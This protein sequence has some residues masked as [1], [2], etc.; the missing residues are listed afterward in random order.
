[1]DNF[2][3][4]IHLEFAMHF[5]RSFNTPEQALVIF[6]SHTTTTLVVDNEVCSVATPSACVGLEIL[7]DTF[8]LQKY[9]VELR[10]KVVE[11]SM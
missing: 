11:N 1:M 8:S 4:L 3:S 9:P 2:S 5:A 10:R 7:S 6:H